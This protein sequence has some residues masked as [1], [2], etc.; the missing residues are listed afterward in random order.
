[1]FVL[2]EMTC[3]CTCSFMHHGVYLDTYRLG[4]RAHHRLE[5]NVHDEDL[6]IDLS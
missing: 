4:S 3:F 2:E 1:M 5:N 6:R